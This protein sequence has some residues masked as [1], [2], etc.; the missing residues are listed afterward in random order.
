MLGVAVDPARGAAWTTA[1]ALAQAEGYTRADSGHAAILRYD[2]A[3]GRLLRRFEL[4]APSDA[5]PGDL[6]VA[7]NHDVFVGDGQTGAIYVIR[8]VAD[9]LETLVPAGRLRGTQQPAI[10]PDRRTLFIPD[11]G[12]GIARVVRATGALSWLDIPPGVTLT[13]IDGLVMRGRDLIAVQ[14]G[15]VPARVVRLVLDGPMT[16]VTRADILLRDS[17]LADEPTHAVVSQGALYLIGNSGWAKYGDDG[18][19]KPGVPRAAPRIL[20]LPLPSR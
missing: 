3:T 12:R 11:Y 4:P 5:A 10:A 1:V 18:A 6:A 14:N 20:Q 17:T 8:A 7:E 13:G 15:V 16:R 9:S 2:L 19:P